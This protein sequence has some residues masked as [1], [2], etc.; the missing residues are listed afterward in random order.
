MPSDK[1]LQLKKK[2]VDEIATKIKNSTAVLLVGYRGLT[3]A[4][5]SEL[6]R[7]LREKNTD[8]KIY[9]N[10]LTKRAFDNLQINIDDS[11][12]AGPNALAFSPDA[13]T[14]LKILSGF[15]KKHKALELR[16]GI[17][18]GEITNREKLQAIAILPSREEL[19]T[20]LA[21]GMLGVVKELAICL[22]LLAEQD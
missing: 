22:D 6:R 12:L 14:P 1:V 11:Y 5:V 21:G 3:V 20:M 18:D 4:E 9:K 8:F 15:S 16:L 2:T 19:L 13:A 17:I 7:N 10:T